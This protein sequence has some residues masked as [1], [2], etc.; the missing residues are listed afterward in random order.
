MAR[1]LSLSLSLFVYHPAR[2]SLPP[3]TSSP[4]KNVIGRSSAIHKQE[5]RLSREVGVRNQVEGDPSGPKHD[6]MPRVAPKTFGDRWTHARPASEDNT[7][8]EGVQGPKLD[9]APARAM[10]PLHGP[11]E[12]DTTTS[13]SRRLHIRDGEEPRHIRSSV[14]IEVAGSH[15]D[16]MQPIDPGLCGQGVSPTA[17]ACLRH[18]GGWLHQC[19][20]CTCA[21]A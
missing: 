15:D 2:M 19:P 17:L 4:A 3:D 6:L 7:H 13:S 14:D 8:A 21:C 16:E 10:K 18:E 9:C 1:S 12:M 11:P 20:K 5:N